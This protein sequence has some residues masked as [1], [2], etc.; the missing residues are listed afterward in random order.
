MTNLLKLT[1]ICVY[2]KRGFRLSDVSLEINKGDKIALIGNS[3]AGKSTLIEVANGSIVP[4]KG[5]IFFC[6]IPI[7]ELSIRNR[8]K[9]GT[10]WQDLRLIEQLN[11]NQNINS[12][13]L[14]SHGLFWAIRNLLASIETE[15]NEKYLELVNLPKDLLNQPIASLSGGQRQRVAIARVIKQNPDLLLADEPLSALDPKIGSKI[16]NLLTAL[17]SEKLSV[18]LNHQAIMLTLHNPEKLNHFNRVIGLVNGKIVI[19]NKT[20]EINTSEIM[21]LYG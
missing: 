14:G 3:G 19:D 11:T 2:S 20:S 16:L 15:E 6:N 10:I 21:S 9:I 7:S 12:G 1:N 18:L 5:E 4:N 13:A 8:R 17:E